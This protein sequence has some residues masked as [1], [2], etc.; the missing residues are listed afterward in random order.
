[1]NKKENLPT[2]N[3]QKNI[4]SIAEQ[5]ANLLLAQVQYNKLPNIKHKNEYGKINQK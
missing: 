2:E 3:R 4:D 5:F 1:M